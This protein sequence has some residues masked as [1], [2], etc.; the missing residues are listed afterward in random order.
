MAE[1]RRGSR[2]A[3]FPQEVFQKAEPLQEALSPSGAAGD[4]EQ[5]RPGQRVLVSSLGKEGVLKS[6]NVQ[7]AE[8]AVGAVT[9]RLSPEELAQG[10]LRPL[11]SRVSKPTSVSLGV[12]GGGPQEG[13]SMEL[14]IIGQRVEEALPLV[15]KWLDEAVM[16]GFGR[17]SIVHGKGTGALRRA[18]SELLDGHPHVRSHG[19]APL[20]EGGAGAT[21]VEL[22]V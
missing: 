6:F 1:V 12:S 22:A 19:P 18:V 9:I 4:V 20:E 7:G 3:A 13:R 5:L 11:G 17:V 2:E 10:T 21:Q 16:A 8:V 15:D 14:N